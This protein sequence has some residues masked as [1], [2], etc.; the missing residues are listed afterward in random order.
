[1]GYAAQSLAH[2]FVCKWRSSRQQPTIRD[3]PSS[4]AAIGVYVV[5][6]MMFLES[7]WQDLSDRFW[8]RELSG[9]PAAIEGFA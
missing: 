5:D 3:H 9:D 1:M 6:T 8:R 2:A 7:I 4:N